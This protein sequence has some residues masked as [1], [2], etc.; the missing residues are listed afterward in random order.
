M[1]RAFQHSIWAYVLRLYSVSQVYNYQLQVYE[2]ST[3]TGPQDVAQLGTIWQGYIPSNQVATLA[4]LI[5]NKKSLFYTGQGSSIPATLADCVDPTLSLSS[6]S[7]PLPGGSSSSSSSKVRQDAIIGVVT[8]L[9]AI[10]LIIL[11][12]VAYR[13]YKRRQEFAHRPLPDP[14]GNSAGVRPEG[15]EFDRDSIG[16]QRRRSFYYAED[17]LRGYQDIRGDDDTYDRRITPIL[18]ER[19]NLNPGAISAPILQ[20]S[21]MNW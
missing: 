8:S 2:P 16:G 7:G 12:V 3:Y 13:Y 9:G 10:A 19:R 11:S 4:S 5:S 1:V 21:S 14:D 18:R 20:E 15:R 6:I 17:S